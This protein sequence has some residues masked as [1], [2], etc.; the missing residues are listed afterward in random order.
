MK[1]SLTG[2]GAVVKMSGEA[3]R[4]SGSSVFSGSVTSFVLSFVVLLVIFNIIRNFCTGKPNKL[5]TLA[6][7]QKLAD[8]GTLFCKLFVG[9]GEGKNRACV[10]RAA[11][12]HLFNSTKPNVNFSHLGKGGE[13]FEEIRYIA[14]QYTPRSFTFCVHQ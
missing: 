7:I 8:T 5:F 2:V 14:R 4:T 1:S 3:L 6:G 10:R 13:S 11:P 12:Q 9:D